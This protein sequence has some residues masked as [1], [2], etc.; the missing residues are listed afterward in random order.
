MDSQD[1]SVPLVVSRAAYD[2]I[3]AKLLAVGRLWQAP[4]PDGAGLDMRG[5]ALVPDDAPVKIW[6]CGACGVALPEGI[7]A[8]M[9]NPCRTARG[10]P[11]ITRP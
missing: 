2:E 1:Y 7:S 8:G 6:H 3:R 9:C 4:H 10:L 11:E 5:I